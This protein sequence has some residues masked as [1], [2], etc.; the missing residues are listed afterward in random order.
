MSEQV[1]LSQGELKT[2]ADPAIIDL[3]TGIDTTIVEQIIA[4]SIDLMSS[5]LSN[6][7]DT[8]TLF[9]QRGTSRNLTIL[10]RL[11]DISIYEIY[12]RNTR[13][14][15]EVAKV[16]YEEAMNWLEKLNTGEFV[17]GRLPL[18]SDTTG[19]QRQDIRF[20]SNTKYES[21]F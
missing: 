18:L 8:N 12:I 9:A 5:Y 21:S 14:M 13:K 4:E 10:K 16:R 15:N 2:V 11:K 17:D 3:I 20:G 6:Y 7:Y 1:F 19:Q